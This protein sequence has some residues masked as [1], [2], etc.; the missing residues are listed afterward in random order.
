MEGSSGEPVQDAYN[1]LALAQWTL[2]QIGVT[3]DG[4]GGMPSTNSVTQAVLRRARGGAAPDLADPRLALLDRSAGSPLPEGVQRRMEQVFGRDFSHV[5]VHLGVG[6]AADALHAEAFASGADI[7]FADGAFAPGTERGDALLAH[8]LQHV[9]QAEEGRVP[10]APGGAGAV[11]NPS[12]PHEVE[13]ERV[14]VERVRD[15]DALGEAEGDI[16]AG[17]D[18]SPA[19]SGAGAAPSFTT[20]GHVAAAGGAGYS[21]RVT[22]TAAEERSMGTPV[23]STIATATTGGMF[24]VRDGPGITSTQIGALTGAAMKVTVSGKAFADD[25][26]WYEVTFSPSDAVLVQMGIPDAATGEEPDQSRADQG[27]LTGWIGQGLTLSLPYSAFLEQLRGFEALHADL[28]LPE[29]ITR[30]RQMGQSGDYPFDAVLGT[31]ADGLNA[32]SR[33]G[34]T[35]MF[36][37]LRDAQALTLPDG[38]EVDIFHFLSGVEA[39]AF[40]PRDETSAPYSLD[41]GSSYAASNWSGD[42]GAAAADSVQGKDADWELGPGAGTPPAGTRNH[43]FDSRAPSADLLGDIDAWGASA[44][45][46]TATS[47][48]NIITGYYGPDNASS[49]VLVDHRRDALSRFLG[50]YGFATAAGLKDQPARAQIQDQI[51]RFAN[52][53]ATARAMLAATVPAGAADDERLWAESGEMADRLLDWLEAVALQYGAVPT[54]P[55]GVG[56]GLAPTMT[57]GPSAGGVCGAAEP[58]ADFS[59]TFEIVAR[60]PRS[61]SITVGAGGRVEVD[62][63][64]TTFVRPDRAGAPT[65]RY[66]VVLHRDDWMG[67]TAGEMLFEV[68]KD[69]RATW[70][71]LAAGAYTL[72]IIRSTEEVNP[73]ETLQGE[74]DVHAW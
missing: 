53:F 66:T 45:A 39:L 63:R 2:G 65:D 19:D 47:I 16:G 59:S 30:L 5:R 48:E 34:V 54:G 50:H 9:V 43:Y 56:S 8:E 52:S 31:D 42:V 68:G 3:P 51:F 7:Y 33:A 18:L 32:S 55:S 70:N 60:L 64:N 46:T 67:S 69:G 74:I 61:R 26:T 22:T 29:R 36:Q 28:S 40:A 35:D 13:A 25:K 27:P 20:G 1:E 10:S 71:D 24:A 23:A 21:R 57:T 41:I 44:T 15:L 6:A 49:A 17:S 14:A 4:P 11:S 73:Y 58:T 37:L 12:D 38:T 62:C 72:E